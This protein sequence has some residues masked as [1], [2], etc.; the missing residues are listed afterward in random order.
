MGFEGE[1]GGVFGEDVVEEGRLGYGVQHGAGGGRDDVAWVVGLVLD[2][3]WRGGEGRGV[4]GGTD[5]GS[6][7]L[8]GR[9]FARRLVGGRA[10]CLW[11]GSHWSRW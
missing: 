11:H 8:L 7:R 5:C 2:R 10:R 3:G 6:R 4:G 9:G 1:G